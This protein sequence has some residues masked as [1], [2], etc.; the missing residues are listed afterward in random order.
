MPYLYGHSH[1]EKRGKMPFGEL[2]QGTKGIIEDLAELFG[3][4]ALMV[5]RFVRAAGMK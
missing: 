3:V 2:S 4:E 5:A 1:Y